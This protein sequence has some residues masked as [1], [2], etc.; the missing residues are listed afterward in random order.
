MRNVPGTCVTSVSH[1]QIKFEENK[2]TIYFLNPSRKV[3]QCV[4]VD[5]CAITKGIRCDK[6]LT[7]TDEH[8]EYYVELKGT[9]VGH[10]ISQL[11]TSI[12]TLG[13]Y[14][15]DRHAYVVSTNVVPALSTLLQRAQK[16]FR[17][18]YNAE[19]RVKEKVLEVALP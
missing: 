19:L 17:D 9:D 3:Y 7:S 12:E 5:G 13:E 1:S 15:E 10:A 2:R 18:R 6:M 14:N 4:Q 11:Q 8:S 16:V